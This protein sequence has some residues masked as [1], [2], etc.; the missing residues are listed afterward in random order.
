MNYPRGK[1]REAQ[2]G[3]TL[4]ELLI[5]TGIISIL[6]GLLLPAV[7]VTRENARRV[8][9][10]SNLHQIGLALQL[11]HES[12][13]CFPPALTQL[14][15]LEYGGFFSIHTRLLPFFEQA[16]VFH[17]IN[18]DTGTWPTDG[19]QIKPRSDQIA[20]NESNVTVLETS[21]GLFLC[22]SDAGPFSRTG[23]NYRGTAGIGPG[24]AM[25]A[26][27][28]DSGNGIFAEFG[29]IRASQVTDGL[30]HTTSF[31][32]RLRGSGG[33]RAE[34]PER[35]MFPIL[36]FVR[37]ADDL[38]RACEIAGRPRAADLVGYTLPG[39]RWFWTGREHTLYTHAQIPNGRIPDCARGSSLPIADMATS[40]SWHIGGVN[41]LM[42]D[43]SVRFISENISQ[44][45]WRGLGSRSGGELVD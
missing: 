13:G 36:G 39:K 1:F 6:I 33:D 30:S 9:C 42:G 14:N 20:L 22:P 2:P 25:S 5:V 4:I 15:V 21:I 41:A 43:G 44:A 32:E 11:Y 27:F 7:Q 3:F 26:E 24:I 31:S 40:R 12:N 10:Q 37:T 16:S 18:F 23:N 38:L 45:V 8:Q 34:I 35:D 19:Y 28:P 17:A 29:P